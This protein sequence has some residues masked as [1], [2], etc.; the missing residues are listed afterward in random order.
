MRRHRATICG[1]HRQTWQCTAI[2]SSRQLKALTNNIHKERKAFKA[3]QRL[4]KKTWFLLQARLVFRLVCCVSFLYAKS[5]KAVRRRS[6]RRRRMWVAAQQ[7]LTTFCRHGLAS[8][9]SPKA[10]NVGGWHETTPARRAGYCALSYLPPSRH[11]GLHEHKAA[12]R[13]LLASAVVLTLVDIYY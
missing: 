1:R 9:S 10:G 3:M 12:K 2:G 4:C 8:P 6:V 5:A 7:P 13:V 11:F